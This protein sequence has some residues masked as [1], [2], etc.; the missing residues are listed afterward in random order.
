MTLLTMPNLLAVI[1]CIAI[2]AQALESPEI[3]T[4][5]GS[6][7]L[8]TGA[9]NNYVEIDGDLLFDGKLVSTWQQLVGPAGPQGDQG[10]KGITGDKGDEGSRGA[11]G[12]D[13]KTGPP[14]SQG[15]KGIAGDKGGKGDKGPQGA[16]GA[17]G[18]RGEK[19]E[20]AFNSPT[21]QPFVRYISPGAWEASAT[22]MCQKSSTATRLLSMQLM[23][24]HWGSFAFEITL[25]NLY[26]S[27]GIRK[28]V[29]RWGYK[30][31]NPSITQ[32]SSYGH[33]GASI[34]FREEKGKVNV[35][36]GHYQYDVYSR[37]MYL[38]VNRY[39]Y[40]SVTVA[41]TTTH[42]HN[43]K[44]KHPNECP[45][46]MYACWHAWAPGNPSVASIRRLN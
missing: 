19:G 37:S 33:I 3:Q 41:V 22:Y 36:N 9:P 14:G 7:L 5:N 18:P 45:R 44:A 34:S 28:Y 1:A 2:A 4:N 12:V 17:T 10:D 38:N 32:T 27:G 13:G 39:N 8:K 30:Q 20:A 15:D 23:Q 35:G 42:G 24:Y 6:L 40:V 16:A 31:T 46:G 25:R 26:Y 21:S 43:H 29:G 11:R